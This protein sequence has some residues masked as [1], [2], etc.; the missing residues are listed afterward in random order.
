MAEPTVIKT[1]DIGDAV[2]LYSYDPDADPLEVTGFRDEAGLAIDPTMTTFRL[3]LPDGTVVTKSTPDAAVV[4]DGTGRY[5]WDYQPT[6]QAGSH[7]YRAIGTGAVVAA[8]SWEFY[9][10]PDPTA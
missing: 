1:Y 3:L 6:V 9:V 8:G 4:R 2:R 7:K 10:R 5:H